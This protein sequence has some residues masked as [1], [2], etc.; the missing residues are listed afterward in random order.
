[1]TKRKK[2]EERKP[3]GRRH[4]D[5]S[6]ATVAPIDPKV[7]WQVKVLASQKAWVDRA[8]VSRAATTLETLGLTGRRENPDDGRAPILFISENGLKTF[9]PLMEM[10]RQFH[11]LVTAELTTEECEMFDAVLS[12][13]VSRVL[14]MSD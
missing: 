3:R 7:N 2:P 5:G 14:K 10:R 4:L 8:E 1:M 12:K 6:P 11:E 9:K 13:I